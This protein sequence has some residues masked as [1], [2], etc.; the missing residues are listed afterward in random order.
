MAWPR[1]QTA[2]V[3]GWWPPTA[4]SSP[5]GTPPSTARPEPRLRL[6]PWWAWPPIRPAPRRD[7]GWLTQPARCS[8]TMRATSGGTEQ[9]PDWRPTVSQTFRSDQSGAVR[10]IRAEVLEGLEVLAGLIVELD[11]R[12]AQVL[13][14]V[15]DRS[16]YLQAGQ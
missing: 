8:P 5:S 13:L 4:G 1:L 14:Q 9:R 6:P 12:C 16:R 7:T 15:G 2:R 11:L 3:I 10:P